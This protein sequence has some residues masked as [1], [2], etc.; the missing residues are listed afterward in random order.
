M[1]ASGLPIEHAA[2]AVVTSPADADVLVVKRPDDDEHLPG[3]WGLPA[4]PIEPTEGV[5]EA[6]ERIG[7]EKLGVELEVAAFVG[8]GTIER[9]GSLLHGELYEATVVDG[10]PGVP[11]SGSGTPGTQYTD[12]RWVPEADAAETVRE[13]ARHGSLCTN[14]YLESVGA[15][16]YV[17][18]IDA[19]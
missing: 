3:M 8:R 1:N 9:V 4:T 15:E 5:R 6:V 7:P 19:R 2:F 16:S 13:I 14:L 12:W 17:D 11:Q 18:C 10:T